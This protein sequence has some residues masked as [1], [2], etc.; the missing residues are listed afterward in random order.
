MKAEITQLPNFTTN[1]VLKTS[2]GNGTL[3]VDTSVSSIQE[4]TVTVSSAELLALFTT[5][6]TLISSPGAGSYISV[7]SFDMYYTYVSAAYANTGNNLNVKYDNASGYTLTPNLFAGGFLDQTNDVVYQ[8]PFLGSVYQQA[9][10]NIL[11]KPLVLTYANSN[12]TTG[13]GN[14]K[15][16][17][18]Y[19][20]ITP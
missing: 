18:T 19:K 3:T 1:G 11:N 17:I 16:F 15:I 7:I 5:P 8:S 4:T 20:I 14:L 12:L 6:K 10:T 13:G 2:G 9:S